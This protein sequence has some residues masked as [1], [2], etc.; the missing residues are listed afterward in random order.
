MNALLKLTQHGQSYWL[1]NLDRQGLRGGHLARR[2]RGEAL[3]GVTSN[4]KTFYDAI[5]GSHLYDEQIDAEAA[6][7]LAADQ[8]YEDLIVA[9]VQTACDVLRPAY[10]ET[11]MKDGYVSLEVSPYLAH[12]TGGTLAEVRNYWRRVNRPNLMIKIPGTKAGVAAVEQAL[13][14]GINVNI[15]LLFSIPRYQEVADAHLRAL[16]RRRADGK[17]LH[18]VHSVASFFLSRI[19][20][21]CDQLVQQRARSLSAAQGQQLLGKAAIASAKLAYQIYKSHIQSDRWSALARAGASPQRLLWA[22]TGTKNPNYRDVMYVEPLIGPETVST[23]PEATIAAFAEHGKVAATLE[24]GLDEARQVLSH[25][26][27]LGID[28]RCL[29]EQLENDGVQKFIEPYDKLLGLLDDRRHKVQNRQNSK[30]LQ[31]VALRLRRDV[32]RMTTQAGSGHPTSCLSCADL[33]A[34]LFFHQLRWDPSSPEARNVDSFVLSKGHAAPVLW[35]AL[36]E[37]CAISEDLLS[38]RSVDSTLEGHPTPRNSWVRAATGSLGQGLSI[39]NGIALAN[40]LDDIDA[41]VFCL[42]GDAECSEGSV[43]EAAQFASLNKLSRVVALVDMNGLG[44]SGLAPYRSCADVFAQRFAAFGWKTQIIDGH[45]MREILDA[46]YIAQKSGPMAIIARTV[47]GKGVSFLEGELGWHGKALNT[48]QMYLAL[49]ELGSHGTRLPVRARRVGRE[50]QR[51]KHEPDRIRVEYP[52][53]ARVATRTGYG[54][55]LAKLGRL[56]PDLVALDGDVKDST[57]EDYFANT[58]PE[59]FV[60]CHIAEQN[61]AGVALGLAGA[62]KRPFVGSFAA[63]L[64]RAADFVR[65]AGHSRPQ[66]LVFC[67]SHA[68]VATGPDGPSQMGL[69]DL[70]MFRAVLGCTVLYPAD[71]VSAE[72]LTEEA[73]RTPGIAYLRTT[74]PETAILYD[75]DELFPVGGS[76]LLRSS[77]RD[78]LTIVA[79]GIT[80]HE[81]LEAHEQLRARNVAVRVIDA[82]SI[83]P[84]DARQLQ[85]AARDTGRLLVVEDHVYEGG[86]GD[87]VSTALGGSC[88]LRRLAVGFGPRSGKAEELLDMHGISSRGIVDAAFA[89][90][91]S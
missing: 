56:Y 31:N 42:L 22:S 78:Q 91:G 9:D 45:D 72:R 3:R 35:A 13:Y 52:Q 82:Y 49:E 12:D 53:G 71:A 65:M 70:A 89:L 28:L 30:A 20:T 66:H 2:V 26:D 59:R 83:K 18:D 81:A 24:H 41:N 80:V 73:A 33:V 51:S 21:L 79:A 15:T 62:G 77:E 8:I 5:T 47:K 50:P 46:L 58:H 16:E 74:R 68:G 44:Q 1:D 4:P 64:T 40:R 54:A 19:D 86:L 10:D 11:R 27:R 88:A 85:S 63:F 90:L 23:M 7:G 69:E 43:W 67:G 39:A 61:M 38:L 57:R 75:N 84:I 29:S 36:W 76:K 17:S 25:L 87:A 34:A 32:I 37:A 60:E 6:S 48:E 55:A 14:E